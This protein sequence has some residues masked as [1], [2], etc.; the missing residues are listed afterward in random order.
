ME[1]NKAVK[2]IISLVHKVAQS[3]STSI[4]ITG[5]TGTGKEL[6]ARAIHDFSNRKNRNFCAVNVSAIPDTLFE[7]EFFGYRKNAFTGAYTDKPGWFQV[8]DNGT[9]FLD[10]IATMNTIVQS[11]LLRVLENQY[12]TPVG[13]TMALET[14]IRVISATND[15]IQEK[16]SANQFRSDLYHRLSTFVINIPP[17]RDRVE[18]I[19]ILLEHF[20][21]LFGKNSGKKILK[22]ENSVNSALMSYNF[23]GNVRELKNMTERALILTNSSTLKLKTFQYSGYD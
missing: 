1:K 3:N 21:K 23:P 12:Y 6:V 22:I 11:K 16:I 10:E 19:P 13:S 4:M 15:D 8:A 2:N 17:L 7:S 18:D 5:E 20:V 9:L 14:D